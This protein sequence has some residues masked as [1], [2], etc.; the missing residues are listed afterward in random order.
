MLRIFIELKEQSSK[1]KEQRAKLES[2]AGI[3]SEMFPPD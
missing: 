2:P 1:S 3:I